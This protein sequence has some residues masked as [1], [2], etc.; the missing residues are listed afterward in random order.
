MTQPFWRTAARADRPVEP[1]A[2]AT[3]PAEDG[4]RQDAAVGVISAL[5]RALAN[6]KSLWVVGASIA[7]SMLT[8]VSGMLTARLLGPVGRGAV[9]GVVAMTQVSVWAAMLSMSRGNT[10]YFHHEAGRDR[11]PVLVANSLLYTVLVGALVS[12]AQPM[13]EIPT[14]LGPRTSVLVTLLGVAMLAGDFLGNF[15]LADRTYRAFGVKR[16]LETTLYVAGLSA[17]ALRGAMS[18]ARCI[19]VLVASFGVANVVALWMLVRR[20]VARVC[21]PSASL[22]GK[23][24]SYGFHSQ[25]SDMPRLLSQFLPQLVVLP[26]LGVEAFGFYSVAASIGGLSQL[27]SGPISTV[28]LSESAAA[29]PN[30]VRARLRAQAPRL[31]LLLIGTAAVQVALAPFMIRVLYGP[32][33]AGSAPVAR[34]LCIWFMLA[35]LNQFMQHAHLASGQPL[36]AA[37]AATG[38][39]V[40]GIALLAAFARG[41]LIPVALACVAAAA[42]ECALLAWGTGVLSRTRSGE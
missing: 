21:R 42:S 33:F 26:L 32:A 16:V 1:A 8:I 20:G 28:F 25:G 3:R 35:G 5:R 12:L 38:G 24:A 37:S 7:A 19:A 31:V 13:L 9:S 23:V 10:F 11:R 22:F 18:P 39:L 15:L 17:L 40:V 29:S 34:V 41:G 30:V 27:V 2:A 6:G 36:R 4:S 14:V